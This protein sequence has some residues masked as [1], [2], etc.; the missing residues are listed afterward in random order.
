MG[1]S[2]LYLSAGVF[3]KGGVSRYGR[4]QVRALRETFGDDSVRVLSLLPPDDHGFEVPFRVDF[5]SFGPNPLGKVFFGAATLATT[6]LDR[7]QLVFAGHLHL[8]SLGL[9]LARSIGAKLALDIYGSEVWTNL[10]RARRVALR[11]ADLVLSDCHATADHVAREGLRERSAISIHWDCV[12]LERFR[13]VEPG[14]VLERYGVPRAAS[15]E[16]TLMTLCRLAAHERHKGV[17][18]AIEVMSR[19][20]DVPVRFVV[21]GGGSWRSELEELARSLGV[22]DRVFFTGRVSEDD[23]LRVYNACDV[24][25]LVT[26]KGPGM[27]EG[28]PLTPIEAAACA[29]PLLVGSED[30]S[31]ETVEDGVSGFVLQP[32]DL[33]AHADVIR[34]LVVDRDLRR[35]MGAAGRRRCEE[36]FAYEHFARRLEATLRPAL[37]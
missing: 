22:G 13:P 28:L 1:P 19:L 32:L 6:W 33:D 24:F 10:T 9:A 36:H 12:D 18:R 34:R 27:G 20:R 15:G 26:R 7:P 2:I 3:D 23:L 37:G 31:V 14:D 21:V 11:R 17:D 8:A 5:A 16:V 35:R 30:G 29:K 4:Y 25:S